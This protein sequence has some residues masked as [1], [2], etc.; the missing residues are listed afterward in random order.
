LKSSAEQYR[1]ACAA[2]EAGR[3]ADAT[4]ILLKL[5]QQSPACA[6]AW[7]LLAR[8][9]LQ[10]GSLDQA[11]PA[12]LQ[13]VQLSPSDSQALFTLG[14]VQKARGE[15]VEAKKVTAVRW[16]SIRAMPMHWSVWACRCEH[17]GASMRLSNC[18]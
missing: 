1:S 9:H 12:A 13:G 17:A 4:L 18:I 11:L 5:L 7:V 14:R 2:C 8:L 3:F 10:A 6:D 16:H 15:H